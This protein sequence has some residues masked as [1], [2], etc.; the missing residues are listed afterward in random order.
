[1]SRI[2]LGGTDGRDGEATTEKGV[3]RVRDLD[4]GQILLQW[5]LEEGMKLMD[6]LTT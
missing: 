2:L 1:M 3:C 5:V 4:F 6:R